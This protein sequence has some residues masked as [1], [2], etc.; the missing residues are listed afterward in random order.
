MAAI[1]KKHQAMSG[2]VALSLI[3]LFV[4]LPQLPIP[5]Y[6]DD[7]AFVF[8]SP[9]SKVSDFFFHNAAHNRF[10]RPIEASL[11]AIIQ[12]YFGTNTWPIHITQIAMHILLCL[13][14]FLSMVRLGFSTHSRPSIQQPRANTA[15]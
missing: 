15:E 9:S 12:T 11:L 14:I 5:Y 2:L 6:E 13:L 4:Y 8:N 3:V 1:V 10:Y 7:F